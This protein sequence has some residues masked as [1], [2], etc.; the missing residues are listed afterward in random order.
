MSVDSAISNA[1]AVAMWGA[2][3]IHASAPTA[4]RL[5]ELHYQQMQEELQFINLEDIYA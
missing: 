3:L 5:F 4:S 2:D 1:L